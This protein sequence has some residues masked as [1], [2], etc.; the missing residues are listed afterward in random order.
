MKINDAE[1]LLYYI[2]L[3]GITRREFASRTGV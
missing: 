2:K 1:K 3:Y